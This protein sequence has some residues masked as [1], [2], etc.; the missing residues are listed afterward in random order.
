MKAVDIKEILEKT[1]KG[2]CV[3]KDS[4]KVEMAEMTHSVT[5]S[6][7][8]CA[9]DQGKVVGTRGGN[10][11][12]IKNIFES[13][14]AT[15]KEYNEKSIRIFLDSP[16]DR[17]RGEVLKFEINPEWDSLPFVELTDDLLSL[18]VDAKVEHTDL[19]GVS[20]FECNLLEFLSEEIKNDIN[21]I[22]TGIGKCNGAT[23][24]IS[25]V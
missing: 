11:S 18:F 17:S 16:E 23:I 5:F 13:A 9:E 15:G 20:V 2:L 25:F 19:K 21:T 24:E 3:N 10:I 7:S 4:V 14:K 22:M 1:I 6:I 8:V 12:A